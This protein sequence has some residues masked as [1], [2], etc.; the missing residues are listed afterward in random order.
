MDK[1]LTVDLINVALLP[2]SVEHGYCLCIHPFMSMIDFSGTTCV[3]C[4]Q[5]VIEDNITPET[6]AIRTAAILK[7][8]PW[9]AKGKEE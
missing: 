1:E 4:L 2:V 9:A 8:Y 5:P 7:A 6:K 3:W